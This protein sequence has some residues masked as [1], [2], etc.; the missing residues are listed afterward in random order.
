MPGGSSMPLHASCSQTCL[1][2]C[3][4][5]HFLADAAAVR[6]AEDSVS[7]LISNHFGSAPLDVCMTLMCLHCVQLSAHGIL[8]ADKEPMGK[9]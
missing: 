1:L 5:V 3:L 2:L 6:V 8:Q 7:E 9:G 4:Q